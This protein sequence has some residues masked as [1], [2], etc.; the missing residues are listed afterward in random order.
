MSKSKKVLPRSDDPWISENTDV[1]TGL[2]RLFSL[3]DKSNA[4][5]YG[6]GLLMTAIFYLIVSEYYISYFN[7]LSI[8]FYSL[9]LPFSFYLFAGYTII[10]TI[11]SLIFII[12]FIF[13]AYLE[14]NRFLKSRD[15]VALSW[16]IF[17]IFIISLF[18]YL[19]YLQGYITAELLGIIPIL[20]SLITIYSI[21]DKRSYRGF[22][23]LV[24]IFFALFIFA[25]VLNAVSNVSEY[26]GKRSAENL[27][28]GKTKDPEVIINLI[29][30][31]TNLENRTFIQAI[32][33][34]NKYYFIEKNES[35]HPINAKLYIIPDNCIEMITVIRNNKS[36]SNDQGFLYVI[37]KFFDPIC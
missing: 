32:H 2:N 25:V 27:I 7:T 5:F 11:I 12:L 21:I 1:P 35:S 36:I 33:S 37:K 18:C 31:K 19:L 6:I 14:L 17:S 8:Q 4:I 29:D 16:V 30:N 26:L 13:I 24:R 3:A 9:D 10:G 22:D 28:E 15:K 20:Y 23:K 34:N